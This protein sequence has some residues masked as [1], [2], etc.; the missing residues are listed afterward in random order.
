MK[1]K[2]MPLKT[3]ADAQVWLEKTVNDANENVTSIS[4]ANARVG[5]VKTMMAVYR[6]GLDYAKLSM[7][8]AKVKELEHLIT[9]QLENKPT[10]N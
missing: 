9:V 5:C 6:L 7:R 2:H 1:A 3:M 10:E 4:Q 8:G